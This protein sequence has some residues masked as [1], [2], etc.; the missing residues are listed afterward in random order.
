MYLL[1]QEALESIE[2]S[3]DEV[4]QGSEDIST[5]GPSNAISTTDHTNAPSNISHMQHMQESEDTLK[6]AQKNMLQQR[7]TLKGDVL[8]PCPPNILPDK[9]CIPGTAQLT[10]DN[11]DSETDS[12][13]M[14]QSASAVKQG[15]EDTSK[16]VRFP[17]I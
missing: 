10:T 15:S 17:P 4:Q 5:P 2:Q 9:P 16:H 6:H 13:H 11:T 7:E 12:S 3:H 8:T 1:Q 14:Q